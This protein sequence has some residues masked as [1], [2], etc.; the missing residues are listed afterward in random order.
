MIQ[1]FGLCVLV[2]DLRNIVLELGSRV[3]GSGFRLQAS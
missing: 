3:Q 1:D 2:L